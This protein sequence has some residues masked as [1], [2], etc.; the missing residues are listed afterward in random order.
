MP[1][2]LTGFEAGQPAL[3]PVDQ[4]QTQSVVVNRAIT[5]TPHNLETYMY[6]KQHDYKNIHTVTIVISGVCVCVC[7]CVCVHMSH[8]KL[9]QYSFWHQTFRG[10]Q[11]HSSVIQH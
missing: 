5:Y 3:K 9:T 4:L 1:I 11:S 7:V 2:C 8:N 10:R 6:I